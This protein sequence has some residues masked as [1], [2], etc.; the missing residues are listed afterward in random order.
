MPT[1]PDPSA[2]AANVPTAVTPAAATPEPAA[3]PPASSPAATPPATSAENSVAKTEET[4]GEEKK[5]SPK[6]RAKPAKTFEIAAAVDLPRLPAA[7]GSTPA[8]GP[9]KVLG[10]VNIDPKDACFLSM[11]GGDKALRGSREFQLRNAAGGTAPRDWEFVAK[12]SG[13]DETVIAKLA[14]PES[15]LKFEWTEEGLKDPTSGAISNCVLKIT[16]GQEKPHFVALRTVA[17]MPPM[18]VENI[19]RNSPSARFNLE[20]VPDSAALRFEPAI[21]GQKIVFEAGGADVTKADPWIFFG[22]S[23]EQAPLGLKLDV[24]INNRGIQVAAV[25]YVLLPGE[26]PQKLTPVLRKKLSAADLQRQVTV[27]SGQVEAIKKMKKE[28]QQKFQNELN[29]AG[30]ARENLDKLIQRIQSLDA[31]IQQLNGAQIQFRISY[32]TG[33]TQVALVETSADAA[34]GDK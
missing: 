13:G 10:K 21:S 5:D 15:D 4:K 25:P 32:D 31:V 23:K 17:R 33:E 19:E 29:L 22:E 30:L 9:A 16:A 7:D 20:S 27:L 28:D 14:L 11:Y 24:T 3:P 12:D 18:T 8:E 34:A 1:V 6:P 2:T 26:K